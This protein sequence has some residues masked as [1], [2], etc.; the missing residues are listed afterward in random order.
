M[1]RASIIIPALN[2]ATNLSRVLPAVLSQAGPLDEVIVVDNGSSDNTAAVARQLGATVVDEPVRGRSRA[3][4]SGI[5]QS[6][7]EIIVF[8]DADCTPH[9]D[10]LSHLLEPF[11]DPAI[12]C[13]AGEIL[14]I[15]TGT[16]FSAYLTRK[17]HL[18]QSVTLKHP[19]LP[20]AQTGNVA[21]RRA[22]LDQIGLFDEALWAGHDADISWRMQLE[23]SHKITAAPR[24]RV[25]HRQD[26]DLAAFLR[27]K[28]RH[29]QGAVLLYKKYKGY[30]HNEIA[31]LKKTYW[32]YR[33]ILKRAFGYAIQM[34][35]SLFGLR[36]PP[37]G[38]QRYQLL[39]E[40]GEKLGRIEGSIRNRVWYP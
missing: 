19:F 1:T 18:A 6:W 34:L 26:I 24:G 36:P 16:P 7:G 23:T 20:Y 35:A 3:R 15:D 25:E 31:S 14:N 33:S 38:D 27:Q 37:S 11:D 13:V 39:L 30:R 40:I 10:W 21:Y 2:E 5:K 8:L 17:G 4:N 28:R 22:V 29:A 32:E 12:G 9:S